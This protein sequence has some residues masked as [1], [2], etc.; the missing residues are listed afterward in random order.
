MHVY[1]VY[2]LMK[3]LCSVGSSHCHLQIWSK[4]MLFG[5]CVQLVLGS[6]RKQAL[7]AQFDADVDYFLRENEQLRDKAGNCPRPFINNIFEKPL[8][9]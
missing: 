2:M 8:L 7:A 1:H 4:E 6:V 5:L 9:I 3:R